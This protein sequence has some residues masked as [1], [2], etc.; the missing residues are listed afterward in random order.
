MEH[1]RLDLSRVCGFN[2]KRLETATDQKQK[3]GGLILRRTCSGTLRRRRSMAAMFL[4]C[5]SSVWRR[6]TAHPLVTAQIGRTFTTKFQFTTL[7]FQFHHV[8]EYSFT[9]CI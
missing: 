2:S 1:R 3:K 6:C 7:K 8:K 4:H 5:L 9:V